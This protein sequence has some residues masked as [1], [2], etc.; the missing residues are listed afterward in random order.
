MGSIE[1]VYLKN[2]Q[3]SSAITVQ[4]STATFVGDVVVE[5][6]GLPE[7][8]F[9]VNCATLLALEYIATPMLFLKQDHPKKP[10]I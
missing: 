5:K 2:E 3:M 10:P 8:R 1:Q 7:T 4:A 9:G 6:S